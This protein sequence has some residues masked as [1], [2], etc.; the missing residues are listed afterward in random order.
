MQ[1][2]HATQPSPHLT[3]CLS[4]QRG[5]RGSHSPHYWMDSS[6]CVH[7]GPQALMGV[8]RHPSPHLGNRSTQGKPSWDPSFPQ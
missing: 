2:V 4:L 6:G 5:T 8:A 1:G 7:T 3:L